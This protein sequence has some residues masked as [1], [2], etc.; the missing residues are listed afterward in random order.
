MAMQCVRTP[1]FPTCF[2]A[3]QIAAGAADA[4]SLRQN[5]R[6]LAADQLSESEQAKGRVEVLPVQWRKHLS[7]DVSPPLFC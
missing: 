2:T 3:C 7:L 5:V 4:G 1:T 6:L